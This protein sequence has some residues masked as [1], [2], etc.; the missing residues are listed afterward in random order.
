MSR[1]VAS[2]DLFP[3][4]PRRPRRVMMHVVDAGDRCIHFRCAACGHDTGW[5]AWDNSVRRAK[6]GMPC[7]ICNEGSEQ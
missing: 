2:P 5:I 6:R 3:E 4:A 7:P 1:Q